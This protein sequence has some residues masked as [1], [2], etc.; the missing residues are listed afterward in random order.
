MSALK[1]KPRNPDQ[2]KT[3]WATYKLVRKLR[4]KEI[5]DDLWADLE[6]AACSGNS[7]EFW[8]IVNAPYFKTSGDPTT[9]VNV[10]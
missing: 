6:K 9:D 1:V 4:E 5:R 8:K 7:C 3:L 2:I 10:D